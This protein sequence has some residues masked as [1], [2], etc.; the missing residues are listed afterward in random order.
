M[1]RTLCIASMRTGYA[2]VVHPILTRPTFHA[3]DEA[4]GGPLANK[5][6]ASHLAKTTISISTK[7]QMMRCIPSIRL[8]LHVTSEGPQVPISNTSFVAGSLA[9]SMDE[10]WC[11]FDMNE[12]RYCRQGYARLAR[13]QEIKLA[14]QRFDS[15]GRLTYESCHDCG[16][17][18]NALSPR[19]L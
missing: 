6:R 8:R 12:R 14:T 1:P 10:K 16:L 11:N 5:A 19:I 7:D 17:N 3:Y 15:R 13:S 4:V 2:T 18:S 9:Q